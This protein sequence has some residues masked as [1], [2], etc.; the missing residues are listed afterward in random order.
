[1]PDCGSGTVDL[2]PPTTSIEG[3]PF[4]WH[5]DTGPVRLSLSAREASSPPAITYYR[6]DT[7][8]VTT[9]TAPFE[10]TA[11]GTTTVRYWSKDSASPP[12][13]EAEQ[14]R[15]VFID[16]TAPRV[17]LAPSA[18]YATP[19]SVRFGIADA[20]SGLALVQWRLDGSQLAVPAAGGTTTV[21]AP[22]AHTLSWRAIDVA[23]NVATGSAIFVVKRRQSLS[24]TPARS[25]LT[26]TRV[27]GVAVYRAAVSV[28]ATPEAAP[29]TGFVTTAGKTVLL[30]SSTDGI[31]WR[32]VATRTTSAQGTASA[33]VRLTK[34]GRVRFRWFSPGDDT[35]AP[36]VSAETV[37]TVR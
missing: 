28:K 6:I 36:R 5:S 10:I 34:A 26:L 14:V 21:T 16:R 15:Y 24:R 29:F 25:A 22:G 7:G 11:E 2:Q 32:T 1:M 13:V 30:Q 8:P 18:E 20:H 19:A 37:V 12:N 3:L 27:R 17:T 4:G 23:G 9:Y 33:S 31:R 35:F